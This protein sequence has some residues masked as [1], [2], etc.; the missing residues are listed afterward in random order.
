MTIVVSI[1]TYA[2]VPTIVSV[3]ASV[4]LPLES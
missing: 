4:T 2:P 3:V 1:L